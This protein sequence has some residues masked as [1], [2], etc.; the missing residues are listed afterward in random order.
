MPKSPLAID[1]EMDLKGPM[2]CLSV[3]AT[4]HWSA[5]LTMRVTVSEVSSHL[6]KILTLIIVKTYLQ[7]GRRRYRIAGLP[8]KATFHLTISMRGERAT[9]KIQKSNY[10]HRSCGPSLT[11]KTS[12]VSLIFT[13][14][15]H[16]NVKNRWVRSRLKGY[17][18]LNDF[19]A[20][21]T[22]NWQNSKE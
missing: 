8:V 12:S 4:S 20:W 11:C 17:F 6:C 14:G 21:A 2:E 1:C 19:Y 22:C 16:R 18:S 5:R 9:G 3:K 7:T 15:T 10:H 13:H